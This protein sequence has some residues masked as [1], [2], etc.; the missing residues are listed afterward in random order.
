MDPL[1]HAV[2]TLDEDKAAFPSPVV[3]SDGQDLWW[4]VERMW[5]TFVEGGEHRR[6][7]QFLSRC[8]ELITRAAVTDVHWKINSHVPDHFYKYVVL[9]IYMYTNKT[10]FW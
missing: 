10:L 9:Y 3:L 7:Q 1:E 2:F 4:D 6:K 5:Y 8:K